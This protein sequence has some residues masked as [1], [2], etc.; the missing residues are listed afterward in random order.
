L[1]GGA[2]MPKN[3]Y[4]LFNPQMKYPAYGGSQGDELNFDVI[5]SKMKGK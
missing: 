1:T 4:P 2:K 3:W 5:A